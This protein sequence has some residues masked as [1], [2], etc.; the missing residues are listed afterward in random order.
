MRIN[1]NK[2][3]FFEMLELFFFLLNNNILEDFNF[4]QFFVQKIN[5]YE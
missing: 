4:Y 3:L 1:K 5:L 2:K